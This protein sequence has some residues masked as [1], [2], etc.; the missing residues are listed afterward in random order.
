MNPKAALLLWCLLTSCDTTSPAK[1][2]NEASAASLSAIKPVSMPTQEA[3]GDRSQKTASVQYPE[4]LHGVWDLGSG[5]CVL[6]EGTES[7]SRFEIT[8]NTL[9]GYEHTD[10][11][12]SVVRISESQQAWR[13]MAVSDIAPPEIQQGTELYTLDGNK[14]TIGEGPYARTYVRCTR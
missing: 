12:R 6:T 13:I 7:D 1:M 8:S 10:V 9:Q 11:P 4:P 3:G 5:P 2:P 14:L